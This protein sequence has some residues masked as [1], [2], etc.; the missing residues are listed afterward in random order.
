MKEFLRMAFEIKNQLDAL[1]IT[2]LAKILI[3]IVLNGLSHFFD[4]LI[5]NR[6]VID[7][8]FNFEKISSRLIVEIYKLQ[9][10][11]NS[12]CNFKSEVLLVHAFRKN[13]NPRNMKNRRSYSSYRSRHPFLRGQ[14]IIEVLYA[15]GDTHLIY[16]YIYGKVNYMA[17]NYKFKKFLLNVNKPTTSI[18]EEDDVFS[19]SN[20]D[21]FNS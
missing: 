11:A 6:K 1:S 10:R 7:Q 18:I 16:R 15:H 2:I 9:L 4:S 19:C 14:G 17:K 20:Y 21:D 12:N 13:Y 3:Q 5:Y 8:F